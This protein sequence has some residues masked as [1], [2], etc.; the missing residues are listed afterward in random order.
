MPRGPRAVVLQLTEAERAALENLVRRR[1]VGQALAQRAR[2][3][4]ACAE[5]G[6]TNLGVAK[7]LGV[8]RPTVAAW[9]GRFA[10]HRL[11]GLSMRRARARRAGSATNSSS[12]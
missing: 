8:S 7:A 12:A 5:P 1:T 6:A 3:V 9:R 11:E 10:A 4:L 2:V